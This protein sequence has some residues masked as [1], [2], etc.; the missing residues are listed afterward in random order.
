MNSEWSLD[1]LYKGYDDPKFAA[2][3]AKLDECIALINALP[4]KLS[5]LDAKEVLLHYI[6]A[7]EELNNT[8]MDLFSFASLRSSANTRDSES[9][10]VIGRLMNKLSTTTRADTVIKKFI[11]EIEN[12]DELIESDPLI[13]EYEYML[14]CIRED[15]KHML[16]DQC[17]EIMALYNI[18]GGS[19]WGDLQ[20]FLTSSVTANYRGEEIGLSAVRNLAYDPDPTVRRDAYEAELKCYDKIKDSVAYSLNSIKLQVINS[21]R[22]RRFSSPLEE[23]LYYARMKRETLEALLAS[24]NEYMHVFRRY[25][26]T[27]AEALG[28]NNG[29]P[30]Y[31]M[32]APLTTGESKKYT[33]EDAK[34]YLLNIFRGFDTDLATMVERAFDEE[35]IDFFPRDGKVGGAFCAGL[36]GH[37]QSRVLTNFDGSFSDIVTLAHELGHAFHNLNIE[38]HRPL[39]NDYSMPVA[40]T[41]STFNEHV[42]MDAAIAAAE[43]D[44]ERLT[45]IE[46]QLMDTTQIMCD[47]YSRY[48]FETSVFENRENEFMPA[49]KLC[50]LMLD[51]QRKAYGDGLDPDF[52]H[53]YMWLCKSH[54]YSS[55]NSFY[56]FPYAFGGLFA[57]GLY[58]K[59][60]EQ[61][62]DFVP[63]YRKLLH[64]TPI[65]S[66]E[67]AALVAD[68]DLTKKD[69]WENSLKSYEK[70]VDQFCELAHRVYNF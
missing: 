35:W 4:E 18:S 54:Y 53:P 47:I 25:L 34:A 29:M 24:M 6:N 40:E 68:I 70:L 14:H 56:N 67:D 20:S 1:I 10:S 37:N 31:D 28:H 61:G 55:G 17:E 46:S 48:L 42:V 2:D 59:Y 50:E 38:D 57:R 33:T 45:L 3:M 43:S 26:R 23:T 5:E 22:L 63:V 21:S 13:K 7:S 15:N 52:L 58:A 39:N 62:A 51:A 49:D 64:T 27:K 41:A 12:L 8:V 19:A 69:F 30:W 32:F 11:A 66:V 65:A 44:A 16:S 36:H 9:Q 60:N